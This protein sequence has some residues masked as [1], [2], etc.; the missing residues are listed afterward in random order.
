VMLTG[1]SN[2]AATFAQNQVND[3]SEN[4]FILLLCL[5]NSSTPILI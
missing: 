3:F 4:V 2:A 5:V 1:D